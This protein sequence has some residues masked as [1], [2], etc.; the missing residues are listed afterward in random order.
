MVA[1][2]HNQISLTRKSTE[3]QGVIVPDHSR[4]RLFSFSENNKNNGGT[5][6]VVTPINY[7]SY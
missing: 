3:V 4:G 2:S 6:T 7:I 5:T 1:P